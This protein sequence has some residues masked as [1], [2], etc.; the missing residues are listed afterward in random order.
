MQMEKEQDEKQK[1]L[2]YEI[3]RKDRAKKSKD[4]ENMIKESKIKDQDKR[5]NQLEELLRYQNSG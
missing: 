5:I 3:L 2:I 1:A 4:K